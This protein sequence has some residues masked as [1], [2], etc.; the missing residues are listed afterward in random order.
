MKKN[1]IAE[2]LTDPLHYLGWLI[3]VGIILL[4]F[5][6]LGVHGL[7]TPWYRVIFLYLIV[8]IVDVIKH[9]IKLQ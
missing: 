2:V 5:H 9:V 3:T 6:F 4:V 1:I 8:M 7:H